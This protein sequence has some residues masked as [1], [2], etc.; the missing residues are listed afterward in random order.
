MLIR[1]HA[2]ATSFKEAIIKLFAE[3]DLR[4]AVMLVAALY[5]STTAGMSITII[6]QKLKTLVQK[7][8]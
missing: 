1:K 6:T 7:C 8:L 3:M 4:L 2:I 5:F